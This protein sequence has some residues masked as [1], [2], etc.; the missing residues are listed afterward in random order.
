[1]TNFP[2]FPKAIGKSRA[3]EMVLTGKPITA[4]QASDY[5]M[6]SKVFPVDQVRFGMIEINVM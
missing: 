5:G 1:M 6:V 2:N 4:K 3:M